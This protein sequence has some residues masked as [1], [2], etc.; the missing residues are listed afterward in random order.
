MDMLDGGGG[1][2]GGTDYGDSLAEAEPRTGADS[3]VRAPRLV[4]E[5]AAPLAPP[6]ASPSLR[7]SGD[8]MDAA[9]L[10]LARLDV[11]T[12]GAMGA[13][14]VVSAARSPPRGGPP[15][16][17]AAAGSAAASELEAALAQLRALGDGDGGGALPSIPVSRRRVSAAPP[18]AAA[19]PPAGGEG[20]PAYGGSLNPYADDLLARVAD[21]STTLHDETRHGAEA[22]VADLM[23]ALSRI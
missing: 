17:V 19:A 6:A 10:S 11:A 20:G 9:S 3:Y 23:A 21:G 14:A 1:G 5:E 13:A 22:A 8:A 12:R 15:P 4:V 7:L 16:A 18:P 2:A